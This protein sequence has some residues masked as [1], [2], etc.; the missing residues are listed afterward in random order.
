MAVE[1]NLHHAGRVRDYGEAICQ[2]H[3]SEGRGCFAAE[4]IVANGTNYH[5]FDAK[6]CYVEG[7]IGR[8]SAEFSAVG[9]DVPEE[10]A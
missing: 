2:A 8:S 4:V 9:I 7:E 5:R 10:F 3:V 6:L 1:L